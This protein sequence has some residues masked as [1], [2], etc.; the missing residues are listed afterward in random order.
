MALQFSE[1]Q[2]Y[3]AQHWSGLTTKNHLHS[4]Y[5]GR[6]QKAS[7]IMRR[8][9][10]TSVGMDL[11]SHLS[12]YPVKY[13]D[14]DDDLTWELIGSGKKNVPLVEAR[15]TANG[16]AVAVGDEA[17][18]NVTQFYLVFPE[19][20]F[21]DEHIIVGHKNEMYSLQIQADPTPDGTNWVY[22]V[23][24]ITNDPDLFVPIE[25]LAGGTRWSREWSLVEPT[26]SKKG[27][28]INF[29][30]PFGMRNTFSMIRMQHTLPGNMISQPFATGFQVKNKKGKLVTFKT[31]MQYEDW[32]FDQQFREE[33]NKL[34]M[35][36]RSNRGL[37]GEYY[38]FG[39]SGHVKSQGA[40]I[41]QQME[42]SGTEF[43]SNFSIP[44]LLSVLMDLSEGKAKTDQRHF[45]AR[46]GERGAVQFHYAL[47]NH[48]QLFTPLFDQT[49]MF[50]SDNNGGMAGVSMA[51]GYG[52]QF[53]DYRGPNGIRFSVVVDSM[54]DDRVRNKILHP[55]G[56]VA[57]SY[58]YDI[59]DV[60]TNDGNP[61]IQKF[62]TKNSADIWGYE[63]GLRN[64]YSASG[65]VTQMS[66]A[67][68]G[69]TV[70][71]GCQVAAVVYDPSRTKS[72][73]PNILF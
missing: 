53:L 13:L 63:G 19:R 41:R 68:D 49:R 62:Y 27:G 11:D 46:T 17:G 23:R 64:P 3:D 8:I 14:T 32:V 15:L 35:F 40:G 54:Y 2:M 65:A 50:K 4:I 39:K 21:T 44:W 7:N 33:K 20:W 5:Q 67:T 26:L 60:G 55:D 48:S 12:K 69:Y 22:A 72:L 10:T 51:Y 45:V 1:F 56:G 66:H 30:S 37:N 57:E 43:Y 59:M 18:L 42:S 38:N 24:L 36:A 6:K 52:G 29:E 9:Y 31:W 61:N 58:R 25:E 28:G 34:L 73:I 70:H 71:R 16:S 47:E